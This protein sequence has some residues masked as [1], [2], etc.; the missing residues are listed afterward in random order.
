MESSATEHGVGSSELKVGHSILPANIQTLIARSRS[1]SGLATLLIGI[2]AWFFISETPAKALW[3]S[4]EERSY[5]SLRQKYA[6]GPTPSTSH[7]EWKY[8]IQALKDWKAYVG[9]ILFFG[10]SIPVYGLSF[11]MPTIVNN[12]GYSAARAQGMTAPPYLFGCIA[13]VLFSIVADKI[14]QRAYVMAAAFLLALVGFGI[15]MG[16]AGRPEITGVTL[17]G[18]FLT[19][20][21]LYSATPPMMAWVS[22]IFEG[23]VKRGIAISIVPTIG[24]FGGV[25]GSNIYLTKEKPFYHTGFG[26]SIA[27]VFFC[28]LVTTLSLR[29]A[30]ARINKNRD[31]IPIEEIRA[32]YSEEELTE[33]GDKSPLYRVSGSPPCDNLNGKSDLTLYHSTVSSVKSHGGLNLTRDASAICKNCSNLRPSASRMRAV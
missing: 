5:L 13:C 23:E 17:F 14:K 26:V 27:V 6:S 20:A 28:G 15:V 30:L 7:F 22:N 25:V 11:T 21:G 9:C 2:S 1:N 19:A 33:M 4:E 32:K 31:K 24:Q 10:T 3:L 8:V 18:I 29:V 16:T 12:L